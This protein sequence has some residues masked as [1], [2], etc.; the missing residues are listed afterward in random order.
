MLPTKFHHPTA[1]ILEMALTRE[2]LRQM[3][4]KSERTLYRM[5][6]RG[7]LPPC[8]R[9]GNQKYYLKTSRAEWLRRREEQPHTRGRRRRE[10]HILSSR[11]RKTRRNIAV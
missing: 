4:G 1:L 7:D 10:N 5:E 9:I 11:K 2:Q 3:L 8:I 6:R